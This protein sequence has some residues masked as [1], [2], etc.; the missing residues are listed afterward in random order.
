SRANFRGEFRYVSSRYGLG[1]HKGRV[2]SDLVFH[3]TECR[4]YV[5]IMSLEPIAKRWPQHARGSSRR[6][7]L[8]HIM[9]AVKKIRRISRVERHGFE[10]GEGCEF[11]ARP[12]PPVADQVLYVKSAGACWVRTHG[13]RLPGMK[14]KTAVAL[15]WSFITPGIE[16]CCSRSFGASVCCAMKLRLGRQ[17]SSQPIRVSGGFAVAQVNRP[18]A[19]QAHFAKHSAV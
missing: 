10:S 8:H 16:S 15:G 4:V 6:T 17:F 3:A 9:L 13:R 5:W 14:I 7:T 1:R 11:R 18:V 2:L 19:G 12:L